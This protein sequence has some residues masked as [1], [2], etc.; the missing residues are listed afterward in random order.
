[1]DIAVSSNPGRCLRKS[2]TF[3]L[4]LLSP[5]ITNA[6]NMLIA[7]GL[8][9]GYQTPRYVFPS[10]W[11]RPSLFFLFQPFNSVF[12]V[13]WWTMCI[14]TVAYF[15]YNRKSKLRHSWPIIFSLDDGF[16]IW[17][18]H[19]LSSGDGSFRILSVA[20]SEALK[21]HQSLWYERNQCMIQDPIGACWQSSRSPVVSQHHVTESS[22][23]M[24]LD[25]LD[26]LR[27]QS[28]TTV[29]LHFTLSISCYA[30]VTLSCIPTPTPYACPL[31]SPFSIFNYDSFH[32]SLTHSSLWLIVIC[33]NY[34]SFPLLT[35]SS[36]INTWTVHL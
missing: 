19:K 25:N 18:L 13:A 9:T 33:L 24:D 31:F 15:S 1:M 32:L 35:H 5:K 12:K 23:C 36:S 10:F 14:A 16:F 7:K 27:S 26:I 30:S 17:N 3:Q 29:N 2:A 6:P 11:R 22:K 21:T 34:D 8:S 4:M 20:D 28:Q